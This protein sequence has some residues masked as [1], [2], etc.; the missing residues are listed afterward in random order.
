MLYCFLLSIMKGYFSLFEELVL[1][2]FNQYY[3]NLGKIIV[4]PAVRNDEKA[5]KPSSWHNLLQ[6]FW[7]SLKCTRK[8]ATSSPTKVIS[9]EQWLERLLP[10]PL[11]YFSLYVKVISRPMIG[12]LK[13]SVHT[14]LL[15]RKI[16]FLLRSILSL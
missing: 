15:N 7:Q 4:E 16:F 5:G 1:K 6:F 12:Q 9:L 11:H 13:F 2:R 14:G 8:L 10:F 3:Y